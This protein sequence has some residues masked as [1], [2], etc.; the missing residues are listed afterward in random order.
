MLRDRLVCG[1]ENPAIQKKLL[2]ERNLTF[3]KALDIAVSMEAAIRDAKS[4]DQ[5]PSQVNKLTSRTVK[6]KVV[7]DSEVVCY[8]C[9]GKGHTANK[10]LFKDAICHHC[11]KKGHI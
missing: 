9:N 5:A 10:C 1:I 2:A 7:K 3:E 11:K 8:R 4:F 6:Q